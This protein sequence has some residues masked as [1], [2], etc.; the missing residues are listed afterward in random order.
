MRL[1]SFVSRETHCNREES[2][3]SSFFSL[4][5]ESRLLI[6]AAY[7]AFS[8]G[9]DMRAWTIA[10]ATWREAVRQPV[11]I[12]IL[13]VAA[14]GTFAS[15]FLTL[16]HFDEQTEFNVIRQM[17]VAQ[18]L[19]AGIV[20]AVFTASATMA[21]EIENRTMLTLLAKPVRRHEVVLGKFAGITMAVGA[22][23]LAM[24]VVSLATV[25]WAELGVRK[26]RVSPVLAATRL[27]SVVTGQA[28][29]AVGRTYTAALS[30]PVGWGLDSL[31][32]SGDVLLLMTG[33]GP[34]L[35]GRVPQSLAPASGG[36]GHSHVVQPGLATLTADWLD[37]FPG[38][39]TMLLQ[40]FV[41]AF[42]HVL[43]IAA[44]AVAV[45]TRLPLVFNA[46]AC[47]AVF[48]LGNVWP[49]LS[50]GIFSTTIHVLPNFGNLSLTG[51]LSVGRS[52]DPLPAWGSSILYGLLY[53]GLVLA[54]AVALFR[55]REVA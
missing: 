6:I 8:P 11:A 27:P 38:R 45:S 22:A 44:V 25:W 12:I 53:T 4:A 21:D 55:R 10:V 48:V 5:G 50:Q 46:L 9:A 7:A 26:E 35:V 32:S 30:R 19:M 14:A 31:V 52:Q 17:A 15:Q 36:H 41:L 24:V 39:V 1:T 3:D 49:Y 47:A 18:T 13:C 23:F 43:V 37:F 28:P 54:V 34:A 16:Y 33:Q 2:P 20:I 29:L 42:V 40:A 51:P